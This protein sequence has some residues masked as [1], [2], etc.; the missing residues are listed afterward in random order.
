LFAPKQPGV[1]QGIGL[2]LRRVEGFAVVS[3]S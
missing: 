1:A 2:L 3:V